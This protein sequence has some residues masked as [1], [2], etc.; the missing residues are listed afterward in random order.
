MS[1]SK[2]EILTGPF[3]GE[4]VEEGDVFIADKNFEDLDLD[5]QERVNQFAED[6]GIDKDSAV[7][8]YELSW[9]SVE[10]E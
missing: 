6:H 1:N 2:Y 4:I 7:E 9:D 10:V 8:K 5:M 3:A